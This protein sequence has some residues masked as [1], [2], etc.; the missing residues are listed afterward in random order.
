MD[1]PISETPKQSLHLRHKSP[2]LHF[3]RR[4]DER[5]FP[6]IILW[7]A[8]IVM[9]SGVLI[10]SFLD[11]RKELKNV[12]GLFRA[13]AASVVR[14]ITEGTREGA[15]ST[16]LI[17]EITEK[18]LLEMHHLLGHTQQLV[19]AD[20]NIAVLVEQP[21]DS[22]EY[23]GHWGH[24]PL[25]TRPNVI[26]WMHEFDP[27][28]LID[29]GPLFDLDL[30]CIRT[31]TEAGRT[32][33][34]QTADELK[35][36]RKEIGIGPLLK[37]VVQDD[38]RYVTLQDD[39]GIIA[40]A[41]STQ[42]VSTW[43][44][45]RFI[46]TSIRKPVGQASFRIRE[47]TDTTIFEG[48]V[49]FEMADESIVLLRVG[50]DA[51]LLQEVQYGAFRR[52]LTIALLVSI[53]LLLTT[54]VF[55]SVK[56][57]QKQRAEYNARIEQEA[58]ARKHWE[59]IGQMAATVAH[60]VRNP[61]NTIGMI[62]QRMKAEFTIAKNEAE[63][64]HEMTDLLVS[65]GRRV[66]KV[67][68]DFLSLGK[69]LALEPEPMNLPTLLNDAVAPL[70]VRAEAQSVGIELDDIADITIPVDPS[71]FKQMVSNLVHNAIDALSDG[72]TIYIST[73]AAPRA[74]AILI[75][76]DGPGLSDSRIR[77]VEKPFVSFKSTGTGLGLPL[78]KRI[79]GAHGGQ[80]TLEKSAKGGLL[81]KLRL[82]REAS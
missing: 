68:T 73:E 49:P 29:D 74:V 27:D 48:V 30:A 64:F 38:I 46:R 17:Y 34:C 13:H 14:L 72:G 5:R 43:R 37:G 62:T 42:L 3:V 24:I 31:E 4:H 67:V 39:T 65:E 7:I 22:P 11:Y 56:R 19:P 28:I 76:D 21:A 25:K 58:A 35:R 12:T 23:T 32:I 61:L 16:S 8:V 40:A 54:L 78:V 79:A 81:A 33:Y 52:F 45:D 82:P 71:R 57:W 41:P 6:A 63:E 66:E 77:E 9:S 70:M 55:L 2:N 53:S 59:A 60:E 15:A 18:R 1:C 47:L 69:P 50:I 26:H 75:E 20:E 36:H 10:L 44:D 80:L 51:A